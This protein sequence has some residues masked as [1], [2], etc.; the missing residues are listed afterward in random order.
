M[1]AATIS[2]GWKNRIG[3]GRQLLEKVQRSRRKINELPT[4]SH[5]LPDLIKIL[6]D[7]EKE[8]KQRK[9]VGRMNP[10][11]AIVSGIRSFKT[12]TIG[13]LMEISCIQREKN[14]TQAADFIRNMET[15]YYEESLRAFEQEI[16][17]WIKKLSIQ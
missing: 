10:D 14:A 15:P 8:L 3:P 11:A 6:V 7:L 12:R 17:K 16:S 1:A 4:N 2:K 5:Y 9:P 13:L